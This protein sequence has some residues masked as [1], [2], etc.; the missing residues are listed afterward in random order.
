MP[1]LESDR[2][3]A[4]VGVAAARCSIGERSTNRLV[5]GGCGCGCPWTCAASHGAHCGPEAPCQVSPRVAME[6]SWAREE[7]RLACYAIQHVHRTS[8]VSC[9]PLLARCCSYNFDDPADASV[10]KVRS[11]RHGLV[12]VTAVGAHPSS[13]RGKT[14]AEPSSNLT[15][16]EHRQ[17]SRALHTALRNAGARLMRADRCCVPGLEWQRLRWQSRQPAPL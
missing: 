14:L 3:E 9:A 12:L 2:H 17:T 10:T 11:P 1:I 5:C 8:S 13:C 4:C 6:R 15:P 16:P 7:D